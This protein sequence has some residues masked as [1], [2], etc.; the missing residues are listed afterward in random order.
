[1]WGWSRDEI[2]ATPAGAAFHFAM[3]A[4]RTRYQRLD[5]TR[6]ATAFT[7]YDKRSQQTILS[8]INLMVS[9]PGKVVPWESH[10]TERERE[11]VK[12]ANEELDSTYEALRKA[13]LLVSVDGTRPLTSMLK[14][15]QKPGID[16]LGGL[17]ERPEE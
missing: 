8:R 3:I 14:R 17:A 13:G 12:K 1:V 10:L 7:K 15:A 4:Q 5:D 9:G 11:G 2:L 6:Q 16:L